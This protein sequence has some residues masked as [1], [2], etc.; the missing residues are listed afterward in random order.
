MMV[1]ESFISFIGFIIWA[2]IIWSFIHRGILYG[3][4]H[5]VMEKYPDEFDKLGVD[6]KLLYVPEFYNFKKV[7]SQL[8]M[9]NE[10]IASIIKRL[11]IS[12]YSL[13]GSFGAFF[14]FGFLMA[15]ISKI[16]E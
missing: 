12:K 1:F 3:E 2:G 15:L 11:N 8:D 7:K 5:K 14:L 9:T 6:K 16:I 10:E 13:W 4:L